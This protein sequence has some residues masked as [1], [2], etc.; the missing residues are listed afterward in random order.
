GAAAE[1]LEDVI[2]LLPIHQ[3]L[4]IQTDVAELYRV[5]ARRQDCLGMRIGNDV[6]QGGV[7]HAVDR[8]VGADA[9]REGEHGDQREAR[10]AAQLAGAIAQI[11]NEGF[12][13][14]AGAGAADFLFDLLEAAQFDARG[15][16]GFCGRQP[17]AEFLFGEQVQVCTDLRVEVAVG[18]VA[19][20]QIAEETADAPE[21]LHGA[22]LLTR[23]QGA[24]D[25]DGDAA[26]TLGFRFELAAARFREVVIL[27]AAVVLRFTPVGAEPAFFLHAVQSR[28]ERAGL[29]LEGAAGHLLDAAGNAQ[30][31]EG[32]EA[33]YLEDEH[34][35]G[36]LQEFGLFV[37]QEILLSD[38]YMSIICSYRMSIRG[39]GR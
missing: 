3:S 8:R 26:P 18:A 5:F 23:F 34:V 15:A 4:P 37:A 22:A 1:I 25:G 7:H 9:Q 10:V 21:R 12:E 14:G 13:P 28:K 38:L 11:L 17:G 31:V 35:E 19:A 29:D 32:A 36:A 24:G 6:E 2:L 16:A 30:A 39:L 27:G 20:Q 33:E